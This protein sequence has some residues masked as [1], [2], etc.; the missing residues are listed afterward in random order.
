MRTFVTFGQDHVHRVNGITFD[1]DCVALVHGDRERVFEIFGSKFCFEYPE[2]HWDESK[3]KYFPRGI[4]E[5]S[6]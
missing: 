6:Q 1:A 3:L 2:A 5:V 4:I